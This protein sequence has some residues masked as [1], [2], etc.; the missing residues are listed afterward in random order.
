MY[1]AAACAALAPMAHPARHAAVNRQPTPPAPCGWAAGMRAGH[2]SGRSPEAGARPKPPKRPARGLSR[3]RLARAG[4]RPG[5]AHRGRARKTPS[6][7]PAALANVL[8]TG[9]HMSRLILSSPLSLALPPSLP[10]SLPLSLPLPLSPSLSNP[11]SLSPSLRPALVGSSPGWL[12]DR[13]RR[14]DVT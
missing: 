12:F 4:D 5:P 11:P 9:A 14:A 2:T 8:K 10:P 7:R 3:R 1:A 6:C 13:H